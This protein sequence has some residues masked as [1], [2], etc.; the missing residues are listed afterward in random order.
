MP[1][2]QILSKTPANLFLH[3]SRIPPAY[4]H[5]L[6]SVVLAPTALFPQAHRGSH[7]HRLYLPPH[8]IQP[9]VCRTIAI[10]C[11][12]HRRT[13]SL[14]R[15]LAI[16]L[17]LLRELCDTLISSF[18]HSPSG[19]FKYLENNTATCINMITNQSISTIGVQGRC[20]PPIYHLIS[21]L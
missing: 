11:P 15:M 14:A 7:S 1:H 13:Q 9:I 20:G 5:S 17:F 8:Y 18:S 10:P 2:R 21:V 16:S 6:T 4:P 3:H 19:F 12:C